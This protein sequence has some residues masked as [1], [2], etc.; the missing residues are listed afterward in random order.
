MKAFISVLP[1]VF[2][3]IEDSDE[4]RDAFVFAA[5]RH[6]AGAQVSERTAP[7]EV[8]VR[9]LVVAVS[10]KTWKRNLETLAPQLLFGLNAALGKPLVDYIEFRIAPECLDRVEPKKDRTELGESDPTIELS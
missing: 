6:V 10:D 4:V 7:I 1:G 3:A 8:D 9:R 5:W 2:D